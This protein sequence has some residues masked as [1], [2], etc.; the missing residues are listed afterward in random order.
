V[1]VRGRVAEVYVNGAAVCDPILLGFDV[2]PGR[3]MLAATHDGKGA[4]VEF[5]RLTVWSADGLLP[6]QDRGGVAANPF[7]Y[8]GAR[9]H[10]FPLP[11]DGAATIT[12]ALGM[13]NDR[14]TDWERLIFDR[15]GPQTAFG[16]P[17]Q[18]IDPRGGSVRNVILL[19][20]PQGA[21][22]QAMPK[23]AAVPCNAPARAIHLLSGV[24]GWGW[25]YGK[26]DAV[27]LIVRL[28]YA[29]GRTEDH[30]LR[31]GVH[32]ADYIR[33]VDVPE[34][35]LAFRLRG[36]QIRYLAVTPKRS[37]RIDLIE[38]IKGDDSSAPVVMAATVEGLE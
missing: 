11:L 14:N 31:N 20:G 16:V 10:F 34:S 13:F 23:S 29:D 5:E 21:V 27:S 15:W 8:L 37:D 33:V 6:L 17:F 4:H 7:E 26:W 18:L 12:S 1:V 25:P 2:L 22:C 38:F 19:R 9:D 28:H 24:S 36:Q 3:L 32:F 35:K 30:P